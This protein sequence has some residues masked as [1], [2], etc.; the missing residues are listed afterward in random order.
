ME[1][2][3][4]KINSIYLDT[5]IKLYDFKNLINNDFFIIKDGKLLDSQTAKE[6]ILKYGWKGIQI[7]PRIRGGGFLDIF[8]SILQIGKVFFFLLDVILWFVKFIVWFVMFVI[9]VLKFL[10]I[11]LIFDFYNSIILIIVTICKLPFDILGGLIAFMINAIGG[12]MTTIWGWDE[13]NLTKQDKASN[14]FQGIDRKKGRKC[15]LTNNN[16]VPFSILLGTI[17]CPPMGVF[18]DV[19]ISGWM[20]ILICVIL[21]LMFYIPGLV[22]ALL[23]IYS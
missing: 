15:Y 5:D 17:I 2:V 4:D 10:F 16:K 8:G 1:Y 11:D 12:W 22:Y 3:Y 6:I 9:A 23:V 18:M 14:Y 20:N 19:G 7:F 21:T 13:S